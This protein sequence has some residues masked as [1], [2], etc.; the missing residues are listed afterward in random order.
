MRVIG[1][2]VTRKL[3]RDEITKLHNEFKDHFQPHTL[4]S[5]ENELILLNQH[6]RTAI[7]TIGRKRW[8]DS[9]DKPSRFV[10]TGRFRSIPCLQQGNPPKTTC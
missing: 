2:G 5:F 7:K 10:L 4:S 8:P 1:D 6:R 3:L 9:S